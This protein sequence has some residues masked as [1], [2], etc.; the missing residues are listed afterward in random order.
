MVNKNK[1][2]KNRS[3][4]NF[5]GGK[6]LNSM[7]AAWFVVFS[8]ALY[9]DPTCTKWIYGNP[10]GLNVRLSIY[11]K[12]ASKRLCDFLGRDGE[13]E[14]VLFS[15]NISIVQYFLIKILGMDKLD[16]SD[17]NEDSETLKNYARKVLACFDSIVFEGFVAEITAVGNV[18]EFKLRGSEGYLVKN[19]QCVEYNQ[20]INKNYEKAR[21]LNRDVVFSLGSDDDRGRMLLLAN[22]ASKKIRLEMSLEIFYLMKKNPLEK[23]NIGHFLFSVKLM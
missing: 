2:G 7:G 15:S 21:L 22:V 16:D 12:I 8:Y 10:D 20:F 11:K 19:A 17:I 18:Y 1:K 4:F 14:K 9:V 5:A 23:N 3:R 6:E 13:R